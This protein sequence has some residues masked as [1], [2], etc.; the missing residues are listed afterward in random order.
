MAITYGGYFT[1]VWRPQVVAE[2]PSAVR[3]LARLIIIGAYSPTLP[4]VRPQ[5]SAVAAAVDAVDGATTSVR[6][7]ANGARL[8]KQLLEKLETGR[9]ATTWPPIS[10]TDVK[11]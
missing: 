5:P 10:L 7:S 9:A 1:A 2:R 6:P 11:P 3:D 4:A 8:L